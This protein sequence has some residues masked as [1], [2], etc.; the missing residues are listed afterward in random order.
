MALTLI[1]PD[2]DFRYRP[3]SVGEPF[4]LGQ[5]ERIPLDHVARDL[6]LKLR[7]ESLAAV[8]PG[9]HTVSVD[10]GSEVPYEKLIVALGA[11][12]VPAYEHAITFR[13][14]EDSER[15]RGLVLDVEEGYS[16]QITFVVPTGVAWSL[17]LYELAL[18]T[19]RR[20][21]E[22]DVKAEIAF[23]T[24]E[25]KPLEVF[26]PRAAE[27]VESLLTSAGIR[28]HTGQTAEIPAKGQVR[29]HPSGETLR[30]ER[31]VALPQIRG[32]GVDGL[33]SDPDGFIPVD[34][35]MRVGGMDD[36]YAVGD[37]TTFPLKQGGIACQQAD[38]AARDIA[39]AAGV[40]VDA[41]PL[42][43][44]LR[45][46]L[47]TGGKPH[48]IRRDVGSPGGERDTSGEALLWWPPAKIAGEYLAPY[49][50]AHQQAESEQGAVTEPPGEMQPLDLGSF[51]F[52]ER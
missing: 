23:V 32:H 52:A 33:P 30:S 10:T 4:A 25:A 16:H 40:P 49:L 2:E 29:L 7:Q 3:L 5:A 24:P 50:A 27:D 45:G 51:K 1:A 21:V 15:L 38:V 48:F 14:Q 43:P 47:L 35:M 6:G 8:D 44:V 17:P 9:A 18:M 19:A 46:Q 20:A 12:R 34:S 31:I 41:S 28:L 11:E 22:M 39:L 37:G 13:G 36:V 42:K 26:G